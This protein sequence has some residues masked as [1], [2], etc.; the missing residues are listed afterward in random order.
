L[1]GSLEGIKRSFLC[2]LAGTLLPYD[3]K[4]TA[5]LASA[6][7]F[8]NPPKEYKSWHLTATQSQSPPWAF[9]NTFID[10]PGELEL[11]FDYYIITSPSGICEYPYKPARGI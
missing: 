4:E 11:A 5:P 1:E 2:V 3:R 7:T 8:T 9:I 10:P 6:N